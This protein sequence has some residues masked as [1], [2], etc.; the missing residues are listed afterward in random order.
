M[1]SAAPC[2][3]PAARPSIASFAFIADAARDILLLPKKDVA[4]MIWHES[5]HSDN[6]RRLVDKR[7][8]YSKT[9]LERTLW[10]DRPV[11]KGYFPLCGKFHLPLNSVQTEPVWKDHI[12]TSRVVVPDRF[13]CTWI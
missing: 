5:H 1:A 10:K 4:L 11:W 12:F 6:M 7:N 9:C 2:L 8:Q 13:H 3:T